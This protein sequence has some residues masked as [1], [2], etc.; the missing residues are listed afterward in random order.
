MPVGRERFSTSPDTSW[1][2]GRKSGVA[3]LRHQLRRAPPDLDDAATVRPRLDPV[4]L[5]EG[6]IELQGQAA[7]Q[8]RDG[9]L[10]RQTDHGGQDG[11]GGEN[12]QHVEPGEPEAGH[13]RDRRHCELQ[14]VPQDGRDVE[15]QDRQDQIEEHQPHER[16]QTAD[17]GQHGRQTQQAPRGVHVVGDR[18]GR[19]QGQ[20]HRQRQ[21]DPRRT[22]AVP[23]FGRQDE[24]QHEGHRER[25]CRPLQDHPRGWRAAHRQRW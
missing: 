14:D 11:R 19:G 16:D 5:H 9:G 25:A 12:G 22:A 17:Q 13:D 7:E 1:L 15:A 24:R 21:H 2:F 4:S 8:V 18:A 3:V 20:A 10:E 23:S 6:A